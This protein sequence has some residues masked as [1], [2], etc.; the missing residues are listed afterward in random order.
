[1]LI[2]RT[3][4]AYKSTHSVM[5]H[6]TLINMKTTWLCSWTLRAAIL[7]NC[8][9]VQFHTLFSTLIIFPNR[10]PDSFILEISSSYMSSMDVSK[11][12]KKITISRRQVASSRCLILGNELGDQLQLAHSRSNETQQKVAMLLSKVRMRFGSRSLIP[13]VD[14]FY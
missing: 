10:K 7:A 3:S 9:L 1:M 5:S 13:N 4:N 2:R 11:K 6:F 14:H 12:K 8:S